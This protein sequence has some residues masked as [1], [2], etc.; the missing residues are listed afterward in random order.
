MFSV[1]IPIYNHARFLTQALSS[2][3]RSPLVTEVL[4]LDDGSHD[5]SAALAAR[6]AAASDGRVRDLTPGDHANRGAHY[7]LNEL[8]DAAACEWVAP[9]NSDDVF[10]RGRFE[11]IAAYRGFAEADF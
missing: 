1:V 8:V 6:L 9:L 4:L 3:L 10:V 11:T 7:R 2:A 5:G